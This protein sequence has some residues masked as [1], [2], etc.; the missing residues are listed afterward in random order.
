MNDTLK[1]SDPRTSNA[2]ERAE[3]VSRFLADAAR[4]A[5]F[6]ARARG[7]YQ[8][9]SFEARRGAR[10]M[11][12]AFITLF[13]VMV[14]VPNVTAAFYYAFLA[15][16]QFVSEA[17]FTVSSGA[18]PK[19]DGYGSVT[20]VPSMMIAQNTL[21]ITSYIESRTL[22]E[23][24]ERQLNLRELYGSDHVDGW[25][26]FKKS[27]P[28]E[29]FT[30]Y[31][32]KMAEAKISFPAGIVT[33]TVRAFAPA[34]AKKV[35]EAVVSH[36]EALINDLNE[37]MR[38]D[39]VHASELDVTRAADQ[40]KVAWLNLER[41]RN[42]EGLI[43]VRQTS[44]SQSEVLSGLESER[45]KALQEYETQS[46]YVSETA[47]QLRVLKFRIA[48][49]ETQIA[50]AKAEL[51]TQEGK[52]VSALAQQTLSGKMTKFASLDLE[53]QIAETRYAAA[54]AALDAART[55]SERKLLYLHQIESPELPEE[56][57]YPRR[58]LSVGMILAASLALWGTCVGLLAFVRNNMA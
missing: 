19:L 45:L 30:D 24:L 21:I 17:K 31:W 38:H 16:D 55:L 36:C 47:P 52:G 58:W 14:A 8:R 39:T 56:A 5:R 12:I 4:R 22:L 35:A 2:L 3:A 37:R 6:S 54:T 27:K 20:G 53:H 33:L 7:A 9:T 51:T 28:I 46:H 44:K 32:G 25:A 1:P 43:D 49:L 26:R 15:S 23:Q 40:L 13:V 34:D 29:K 42:A 48:A 18:L 11:R 50:K 10:A 41:A 57:R